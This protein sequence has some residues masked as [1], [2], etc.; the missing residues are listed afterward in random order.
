[1][2]NWFYLWIEKSLAYFTDKIVCISEAERISA[3]K[4]NVADNTKLNVILNGIDIQLI[5]KENALAKS[6]L[7]IP[8]D[9]FLVGMVGRISPQ[10][11]PDIFIRSA[12]LI[13]EKIPNAWFIIVGDGELRKEI[14]NYANENQIN[15]HITGWTNQPY[16]YLKMF[17]LAM[18]L[19]RWEG[20]GLAITEYMAAKVNFIATQVDAIPTIVNDKVNGILVEVDSPEQ[21][22][23]ACFH[24]YT[25]KTLALK[26]RE[27]AYETVCTKYNI[28]RVA[29]QHIKMFNDVMKYNK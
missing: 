20:F 21:V 9:A 13:K 26:L 18:L 15:L 6:E 22:A 27:K 7:G 25:N 16:A 11:A 12:K 4:H 17:D 24:L 1:M 19:S 3:I 5:E 14:E 2:K 28:H 23:D 29:Q 8:Q 10:K